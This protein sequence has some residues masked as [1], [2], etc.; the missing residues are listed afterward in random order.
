MTKRWQVVKTSLPQSECELAMHLL[1]E[2][3]CNGAVEEPR[4]DKNWAC[5]TA[6]FDASG[7]GSDSLKRRIKSAFAA[8]PLLANARLEIA[9][10]AMDDWSHG[11]KQWFRPFAIVPGITVT[12]SWENYFPSKGESVITLDPGMAFGTG[13]HPTTKLCAKAIWNAARKGASSLV[14]V[15]TGSGLLAL[16]GRKAGIKRIVAVETDTDARRVAQENLATNDA[17]DI[18]IADSLTQVTGEFDVVVANILLSTLIH[19]SGELIG[20][21]SKGGRLIL[22]GITPDQEAGIRPAFPLHLAGIRH[23]G[24]WSQLTFVNKD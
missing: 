14:D 9:T 16:V 17:D 10:C 2:I 20:H 12:P 21:T 6:Y 24:G 13:L 4:A 5:L 19:L 8:I 7:R 15:G 18:R 3:G 22:S 11:W 23:E 1:H